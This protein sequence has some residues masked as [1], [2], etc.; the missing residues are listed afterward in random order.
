MGAGHHLFID[1]G[2]GKGRALLLA[3]ELP[4]KKIVGIEFSPPLHEIARANWRNYLS[5]T[6]RCKAVELL[7]L[8]V[9]EYAIP[10]EPAVMCLK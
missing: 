7:C 9:V 2:S 6:Q 10:P 5:A 8:D 3:S 1:F 4:F